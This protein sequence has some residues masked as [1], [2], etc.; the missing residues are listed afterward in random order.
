M[1]RNRVDGLRTD[2]GITAIL[3]VVLVAAAVLATSSRGAPPTGSAD[4]SVTKTDAK[5][6]VQ[7]GAPIDYT[8]TVT[9][10]GPDAAV[11]T[12][13]TDKLPQGTTFVSATTKSGTCTAKGAKVTCNLGDLTKGGS[14]DTATVSL[15]VTAPTN[16]GTISNTADVTSDTADPN[17]ANNSATE[18]TTVAGGGSAPSCLGSKATIVGTSASETLRGGN[19]RD[20][21]FASGGADQIYGLGG[22]DL[23]CG[24]GGPDRIKGGD[25]NDRLSGGGGRDR[26]GG[27][28]G[29]DIL[30]GGTRADALR[31]GAGDDLLAGGKGNDRCSGGPGKD[32]ERSC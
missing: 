20:V 26:I 31:G 23:I 19:G 3:A 21:I 13:L 12:V 25:A 30:K 27:Q 4:L 7:P 28:A 29:D 16:A 5:D 2:I 1:K 22:K 14:Y 9:N 17:K 24:A 18:T 6:P 10:A 32:V 8:I 11:N 15:R